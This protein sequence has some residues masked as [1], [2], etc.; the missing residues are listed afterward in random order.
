MKSRIILLT[1][2]LSTVS[3]RAV[4][5]YAVF[6]SSAIEDSIP[7]AEKILTPMVA[8]LSDRRK[9]IHSGSEKALKLDARI[10]KIQAQLSP[11]DAKAHQVAENALKSLARAELKRLEAESPQFGSK[12]YYKVS[13][14]IK[15]A[16]LV[17]NPQDAVDSLT[18]Q[19]DIDQLWALEGQERRKTINAKLEKQK[20]DLKSRQSLY[21]YNSY[22][23]LIIAAQIDEINAKLYPYSAE[24]Y[25]ENARNYQNQAELKRQLEADRPE[26]EQ[27]LSA[28]QTRVTSFTWN[29]VEAYNA[30]AEIYE[31]EA[32]LNPEYDSWYKSEAE[33]YREL[34]LN[35]DKREEE[36][37]RDVKKGEWN[38]QQAQHDTNSSAWYAIEVERLL[39]YA[40]WYPDEK[41]RYEREASEA[42]L[43]K[44]ELKSEEIAQAEVLAEEARRRN[45]LA[46]VGDFSADLKQ[47]LERL[48]GYEP[49]LDTLLA[50]SWGQTPD[51]PAVEKA[52]DKVFWKKLV[53]LASSQRDEQG[54]YLDV[55]KFLNSPGDMPDLS[56]G[57]ENITDAGWYQLLTDVKALYNQF[58]VG[59]VGAAG[60]RRI[61]TSEDGELTVERV[62]NDF[63]TKLMYFAG[64]EAF[65]R[66]RFKVVMDYVASLSKD[67]AEQKRVATDILTVIAENSQRCQDRALS[68]LD[69]AEAYVRLGSNPTK[70]ALLS[71]LVLNYKKE[72][73]NAAGVLPNSSETVEQH[74]FMMTHF[75]KVLGLGIQRGTTMGFS[76]CGNMRRLDESLAAFLEAVSLDGV[77]DFIEHNPLWAPELKAEKD[78]INAEANALM[79]KV[80]KLFEDNADW[81]DA[82][83]MRGM[84]DISSSKAFI[85]VLQA[86]NAAGEAAKVSVLESIRDKTKPQDFASAKT[87]WEDEISMVDFPVK[88]EE[89]NKAAEAEFTRKAFLKEYGVESSPYAGLTNGQIAEMKRVVRSF[90]NSAAEMTEEERR[91]ALTAKIE[92]KNIELDTLMRGLQTAVLQ[93]NQDL[94][95]AVD[96]NDLDITLYWDAA[97][98][99]QAELSNGADLQ[100]LRREIEELQQELNSPN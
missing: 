6:E 2:L 55:F 15:R 48:S 11:E 87:I 65:Y 83:L 95:A 81:D 63:T 40:E 31:I 62:V 17:L 52:V 92:E 91:R 36:V 77:V 59:A 27:Q 43:K 23:Y 35:A 64:Q 9:K 93:A 3:G 96:N 24:T 37:R 19:S 13:I 14:G 58:D 51:M 69:E 33:R 61:N 16:K 90:E 60:V 100:N 47:K 22:D 44:E 7:T 80:D 28:L 53:G 10:A 5:E 89:L 34:A 67:D 18:L 74:L 29:S 41:L 1:A 38:H 4:S 66:N 73:L 71:I 12:E 21:T 25:Q 85:D 46:N 39:A 45:E 68:G 86:V 78:R 30:Q 99:A 26:L 94:E 75:N 88:Q 76:G 54:T 79:D 56:I 42:E 98:A 8:K 72:V 32:R 49:P 20:E 70:E 50:L 82:E 57:Q 97:E 84:D